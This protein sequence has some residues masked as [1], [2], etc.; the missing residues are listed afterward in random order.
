MR[1]L[2]ENQNRQAYNYP[3]NNYYDQIEA[4]VLAY[5]KSY[6][7]SI[8]DTVESLDFPVTNENRLRLESIEMKGIS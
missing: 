7:V 8:S 4:L 1:Y 5:A 6:N 3:I 2:N